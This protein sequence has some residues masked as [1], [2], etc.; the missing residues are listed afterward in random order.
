VPHISPRYIPHDELKVI[1]PSCQSPASGP[2]PMADGTEKALFNLCPLNEHFSPIAELRSKNTFIKKRP[3]AAAVPGPGWCFS[4]VFAD[5]TRFFE[6]YR[7]QHGEYTP[8]PETKRQLKLVMP[9]WESPAADSSMP[10]G[11][12]GWRGYQCK[13]VVK[14]PYEQHTDFCEWQRY[15]HVRTPTG[16]QLI[17]HY[18]SSTPSVWYGT[19]FRC[20]SV[21]VIERDGNEITVECFGGVVILTSTMMSWTIESTGNPEMEASYQE[22]V[23]GAEKVMSGLLLEREND[24]P[25]G[26]LLSP[27]S[28]PTL[29]SP[30]SG[31]L[32]LP[33][34]L[35]LVQ[36]A[37]SRM[38]LI[39]N[40]AVLAASAIVLL[41]TISD[42]AA[43]PWSEVLLLAWSKCTEVLLVVS[44]LALALWARRWL[45]ISLTPGATAPAPAGLLCVIVI[46]IVIAGYSLLAKQCP[47]SSAL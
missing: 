24:T 23:T 47:H 43:G 27:I 5:G 28:E 21:L 46:V 14:K 13:T 26:S 45:S 9:R 37:E 11:S 33:C 10:A 6:D 18:S 2:I 19:T 40:C 3:L 16:S 20:E 38:W 15:V 42:P 17:L 4:A 30:K 32:D 39:F 29:A 7:Q 41:F 12:L 31:A 8:C 35:D 25:P 34:D 1:S 22:L 44:V 36:G